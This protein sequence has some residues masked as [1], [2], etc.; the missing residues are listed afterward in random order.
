MDSAAPFVILFYAT[1]FAEKVTFSED[2]LDLDFSLK[3]M[4]LLTPRQQKALKAIEGGF[5]KEMN[6]N[7]DSAFAQFII[8]DNLFNQISSVITS[9]DKMFSVRELMK[10][11]A[12]AAPVL[13]ML[14]TTTVGTV[15]PDFVDIYGSG[16]KID[17]V[18][19]PSHSIFLDGFKDAKMSGIYMDKNG[20]WKFQLNV[21]LQLNVETLPEMWDAARNI[22]ATLVFKMKVTTDEKNPFNKKIVI[23]PKN[24]EISKL[25]VLSGEEVMDVEQMMIQSLVNIQL[26]QVKKM[27]TEIPINVGTLLNKLP[28][29]LQCLGFTVS[30]FDISFKKSQCQVSAYFKDVETPNKQVCEAFMEELRKAP[31]MIKKQ[32]EEHGPLSENLKSI[33]EMAG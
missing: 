30:D 16:K 27:L 23:L 4:N 29:E 28:Q 22:Y 26:E 17:V 2:Y 3:H 9:I 20:N 14:T 5:Y 11:N 31:D 8:D 32:L 18:L 1:Q 6:V 21:A 25:K 13:Q 15:L 7:G 19:S 24:I 10:N 33:A 12:K